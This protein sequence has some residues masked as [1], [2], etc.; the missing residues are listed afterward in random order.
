MTM[1]SP[2]ERYIRFQLENLTA[3]NEHRTFEQISF[4]IAERRLSSNILPA[5]GPVSAGGDQGR[6]AE[7]YYTCL[8]RELPGAGGFVGRATTEPLVVACSVQ[9]SGL[10]SKIRADLESICGQGAPVARVAFFAV[11]EIP[12]AARHRLQEYARNTHSVSRA[13]PDQQVLRGQA[14][15]PLN[16][17][18]AHPGWSRKNDVTG[19]LQFLD[20]RSGI[21]S[22]W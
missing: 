19:K 9:R 4:R 11:Q 20:E 3:R 8:P 21:T 16:R 7:S 18:L 5:T 14:D 15:V 10:D 2:T 12:V 17:W 13:R 1:P 6:D 22:L